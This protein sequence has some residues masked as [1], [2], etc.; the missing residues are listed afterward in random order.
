MPRPHYGRMRT[1]DWK[2]I[3]H[4]LDSR[5][6]LFRGTWTSLLFESRYLR[7]PCSH[8]HLRLLILVFPHLVRDLLDD[9]DFTLAVSALKS[10][11]DAW[12]N[13]LF[14]VHL[15]VHLSLSWFTLMLEH[16]QRLRCTLERSASVIRPPSIPR[17]QLLIRLVEWLPNTSQLISYSPPVLDGFSQCF[18]LLLS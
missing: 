14:V 9:H 17:F 7:H 8:H 11:L 16:F 18:L 4:G 6:V 5:L 13:S 1:E 3:C 15:R 2:L 12:L 10:L